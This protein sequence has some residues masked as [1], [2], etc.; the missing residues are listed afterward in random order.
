MEVKKL[1][2]SWAIPGILALV[3]SLVL[4]ACGDNTPTTGAATTAV[5]VPHTAAAL[6]WLPSATT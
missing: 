6:I 3:L 1:K 2:L 5:P 4:G